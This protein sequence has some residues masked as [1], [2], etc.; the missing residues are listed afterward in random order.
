MVADPS[1]FDMG[2]RT[3]P[4]KMIR[5]KSV[6]YRMIPKVLVLIRKLIPSTRKGLDMSIGNFF[7]VAAK[8]YPKTK[9]STTQKNS[10]KWAI[11]L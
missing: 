3:N 8:S 10:A 6:M 5:R 11:K 4:I 1:Y 2:I 7:T 9:K